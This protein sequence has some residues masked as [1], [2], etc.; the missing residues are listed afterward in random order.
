[1]RSES[2]FLSNRSSCVE[3]DVPGYN[4]DQPF[5]EKEYEKMQEAM[6][7]NTEGE[8]TEEKTEGKTEATA[9]TAEL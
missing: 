8:T 5:S 1:M 9:E 3:M 4:Q 7:E 2:G 6:S